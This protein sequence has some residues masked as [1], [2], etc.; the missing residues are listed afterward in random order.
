[1]IQETLL[2]VLKRKE[3]QFQILPLV[4]FLVCKLNRVGKT[5]TPSCFLVRLKPFLSLPPTQTF[6]S[7]QPVS[8]VQSQT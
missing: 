5:A 4:E 8:D 3:I 1:M 2:I 6:F 7:H